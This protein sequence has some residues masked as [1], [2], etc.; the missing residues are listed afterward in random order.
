[1]KKYFFKVEPLTE[2]SEDP[3]RSQWMDVQRNYNIF[4]LHSQKCTFLL[5]VFRLREIFK[6]LLLSG[7]FFASTVY[8]ANIDTVIDF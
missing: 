5:L 6:Y 4:F 1:M 2:R 3:I 7:K 8:N